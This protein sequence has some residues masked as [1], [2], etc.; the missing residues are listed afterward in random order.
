MCITYTR[1][2]KG[3]GVLKAAEV[4]VVVATDMIRGMALLCLVCSASGAIARELP[5]DRADAL[6]HGY[7]G[8]GLSVHGPAVLVRKGFAG[9]V[10]LWAEHYV[11]MIS[12]ASVDVR[13][14]ASPYTEKR[15]QNSTG[16]DYVVDKTQFSIGYTQSEEND[17]SAQTFVAGISQDLFG[18]LTT[19]S[20]NFTV[21]QDEVRRRGDDSFSED[22]DRRGFR[23]D[24]TQVIT[25]KLLLN[26]NYEAIV[27]EGFLNNPYRSVRYL[28]ASTALGYAYQSELYPET[29]TSSAF[30]VRGLYHLPYRA[31]VS[32]EVRRFQDSWGIAA[33]NGSIGYTHTFRKNW[34]AGLKYRFYQQTAADFYSDLFSRADEQNFLARDKELA[35]FSSHTLGV[36]LGYERSLGQRLGLDH[37][38]LVAAVDYMRIEYDDFRDVT[39]GGLA[40][41]EPLFGLDAWIFRFNLSVQ[42]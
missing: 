21:G 4:V 36:E 24:V 35:T 27:D 5:V 23:L 29:R 12:S 32:A 31:S 18:D 11:D 10:S 14:T 19:V 15:T 7:E 22:I 39:A 41:E 37:I 16:V 2:E 17:Y 30:A 8:D 25:P 9:K 1:P 38:N 26:F 13:A 6:Y 28:D 34:L 33:N 42:Y 20:L 3:R 40:G